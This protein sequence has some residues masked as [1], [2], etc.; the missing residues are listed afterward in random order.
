MA[1]SQDDELLSI[2]L[3]S[4]RNAA[5]T[6]GEGSAPYESIRASVEQHVH[7]MKT[8]GQ[9]TNITQTRQAPSPAAPSALSFGNLAHRPKPRSN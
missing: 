6:F 1:T 3:V 8:N 2:L 4:L 5:A 7:S 9:T